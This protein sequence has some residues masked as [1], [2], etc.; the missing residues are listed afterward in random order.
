MG[1][2]PIVW[3]LVV[4]RQPL[5]VGAIVHVLLVSA[6]CQVWIFGVAAWLTRYGATSFKPRRVL[7]DPPQ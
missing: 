4:V 7:V 1:I 3:W 2:A 6:A 5:P